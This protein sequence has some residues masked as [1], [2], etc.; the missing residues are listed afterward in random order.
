[1]NT[2]KGHM[3][4]NSFDAFAAAV[5]SSVDS[6]AKRKNYTDNGPDGNNKMLTVMNALGIH[7]HHA[8]GEIIYKAGEFLKTPRRVLLEKI[9]G[10]SFVLW[11]ETPQD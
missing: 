5:K 3:E 6:H 11:R 8:I 1:M 9:A 4:P 7:Q 2:N 10:W